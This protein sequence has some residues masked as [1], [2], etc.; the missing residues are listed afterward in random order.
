MGQMALLGGVKAVNPQNWWRQT[1]ERKRTQNK[2]GGGGSFWAGRN[3]SNSE[4]T[5]PTSTVVLPPTTLAPSSQLLNPTSVC[6]RCILE[7]TRTQ[8]KANWTGLP[9]WEEAKELHLTGLHGDHWRHLEKQVNVITGIWGHLFE[10]WGEEND[11]NR[12]NGYSAPSP[13]FKAK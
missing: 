3:V 6:P 8:C 2:K 7:G 4:R 1:L 5:S 9:H 12:Q 10:R 13:W 11:E